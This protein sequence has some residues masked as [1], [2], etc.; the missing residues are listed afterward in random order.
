MMHMR[1]TA[2]HELS[3]IL[4]LSADR[5][6][7][8]K[9]RKVGRT[10]MGFKIAK[11]C[12]VIIKTCVGSE[13]KSTMEVAANSIIVRHILNIELPDLSFIICAR[14]KEEEAMV[15]FTV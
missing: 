8:V 6:S 11:I 7:S 14:E 3:T 13:A 5:I 4:C 12:P 10:L 15:G 2:T 1:K 9:V